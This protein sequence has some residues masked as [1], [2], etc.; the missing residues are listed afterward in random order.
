[1]T[2]L[3]ANWQTLLTAFVALLHA[4]HLPRYLPP[5][6]KSPMSDTSAAQTATAGASPTISDTIDKW[7]GI[8]FQFIESMSVTLTNDYA[9]LK[10][11]TFVQALMPIVESQAKGELAAHGIPVEPMVNIAAAIGAG[12]D[13][14]AA[15]HPGISTP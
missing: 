10:A 3:R 5:K 9:A 8:A 6:G 13:Q 2:W 12:M 1:M 11:N 4:V 14:L 15:L 7:A